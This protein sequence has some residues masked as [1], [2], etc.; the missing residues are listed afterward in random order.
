ME[1]ECLEGP[2]EEN[3]PR[4][5]RARGEGRRG[6]FRGTWVKRGEL[7]RTPSQRLCGRMI[8]ITASGRQAE[9]GLILPYFGVVLSQLF[10]LSKPVSSSVTER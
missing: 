1:R 7:P 8:N 5:A 2:A 9:W 3:W 4:E 10:H 6:V